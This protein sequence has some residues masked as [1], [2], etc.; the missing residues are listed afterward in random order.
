MGTMREPE[1]RGTAKE[2]RQ[3][4]AKEESRKRSDAKKREGWERNDRRKTERVME[5][6]WGEREKGRPGAEPQTRPP[7]TGTQAD[8]GI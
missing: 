1:R 2:A 4:N 7:P 8:G 6:E 3:R 5:E